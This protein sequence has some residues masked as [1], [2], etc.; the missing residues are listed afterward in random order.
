MVNQS[1]DLHEGHAHFPASLRRLSASAAW[2]APLRDQQAQGSMSPVLWAL[3]APCELR[4]WLTTSWVV[5]LLFL[6]L[7]AMFPL[8]GQREPVVLQGPSCKKCAG[9]RSPG[10]LWGDTA[11]AASLSQEKLN[12]A[13]RNTASHDGRASQNTPAAFPTQS[14]LSPPAGKL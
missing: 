12:L 8:P 4:R 11:G 5:G 1:A 14:Y 7:P 2:P 3:P 9:Q 13:S 6:S 10:M